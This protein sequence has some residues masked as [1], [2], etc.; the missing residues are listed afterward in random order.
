MEDMPNT[1]EETVR[2][3]YRIVGDLHCTEDELARIV[4]PDAVFTEHPNPI[5]PRGAVRSVEQNLHGF[6]AGRALLSEQAIEVLE[7]LVSG[8][9]AA[10]RATWSGTVG[11]DRG[12]FTAGTELTCVMA[13]FLTVR[14]NKIVVHDTYDCYPPLPVAAPA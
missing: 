8:D 6:R 11:V 10:V 1:V 14:D 13:A 3:Y 4:A 5:A 7:V 9:R 12:P 2:E